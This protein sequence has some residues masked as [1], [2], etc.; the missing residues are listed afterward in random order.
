MISLGGPNPVRHLCQEKSKILGLLNMFLKVK[1][2]VYSALSIW[3]W[4][5]SI[6][7]ASHH[8]E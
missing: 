6:Y 3:Y 8:P 7:T 5:D 2:L 1:K 4:S